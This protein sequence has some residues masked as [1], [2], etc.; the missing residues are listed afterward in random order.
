MEERERIFVNKGVRIVARIVEQEVIKTERGTEALE[1]RVT[2]LEAVPPGQVPTR[3]SP[4]ERAGGRLKIFE[5][6][7]AA[8]ER[9]GKRAVLE[10]IY[11]FSPSKHPRFARRS[12]KGIQIN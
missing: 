6:S 8:G 2:R 4:R 5:D 10:S 11:L 3:I 7:S 1:I 12:P 9:R